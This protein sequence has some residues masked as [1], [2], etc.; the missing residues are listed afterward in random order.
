MPQQTQE[1]IRYI[2][3]TEYIDSIPEVGGLVPYDT[4]MVFVIGF[5]ATVFILR[6]VMFAPVFAVV[7]ALF[8]DR[9]KKRFNRNF[10]LTIPYW[11]GFKTPK[12]VPPV[13]EKEFVE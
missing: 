9:F 3:K 10:Y 5:F 8:Y 1:K 7:A 2:P 4:F 11:F 12:G 13:T 6:N